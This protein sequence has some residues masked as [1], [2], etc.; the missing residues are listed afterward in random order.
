MSNNI[1]QPRGPAIQFPE[2]AEL[3]HRAPMQ[4]WYWS[5]H[6]VTESQKHLGFQLVFFVIPVDYVLSINPQENVWINGG[7]MEAAITQ[8]DEKKFSFRSQVYLQVT[9]QFALPKG[10]PFSLGDWWAQDDVSVDVNPRVLDHLRGFAQGNVGDVNSDLR[11]FAQRSD[12]VD[13]LLFSIKDGQKTLS[14]DL[15][16]THVGPPVLHYGGGKHPYTF[17]GYTYYY[18]RPRTHVSGTLTTSQAGS[19]PTTEAVTGSAWFDRQWGELLP[20]CAHGWWWFA[21]Q[22]EGTPGEPETQIMVVWCDPSGDPGSGE[23]FASISQVSNS[24]DTAQNQ[25]LEADQVQVRELGTW[26]SPITHKTYPSGWTLVLGTGTSQWELTIKPYVQDQEFSHTVKLVP[27]W[28][29]DC[30]VEGTHGTAAVSGRAYVE[31]Q[32]GLFPNPQT[33]VPSGGIL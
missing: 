33:G 27:Y 12:G 13:N 14:L 10:T 32:L 7:A 8:I 23:N 25:V 30:S 3:I 2:S 21:I 22:M 4:W 26:T 15:A 11:Y 6:L 18:S 1:Y 5:G 19:E 20:A 24:S 28:E 16:A 31:L 17:G 29:G 9:P